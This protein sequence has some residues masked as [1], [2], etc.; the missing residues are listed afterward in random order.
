MG[1][2]G[3]FGVLDE[4]GCV[5]ASCRGADFQLSDWDCGVV[6]CRLVYLWDVSVFFGRFLCLMFCV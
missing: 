1:R 5:C 6:V 4:C 3:G 2:M